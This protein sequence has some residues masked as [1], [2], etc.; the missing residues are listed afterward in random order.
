M[1]ESATFDYVIVGA[2]SAGCVLA[3]RLSEDPDVRVEDLTHAA[4]PCEAFAHVRADDDFALFLND[5]HVDGFVN[6]GSNGSDWLWWRGPSQRV[7]DAMRTPV[8]LK[9]GRN[10]VLLKVKN[11]RGGAGFVLAFSRRDG[12]P[13][14]GLTCDMA[15]ADPPAEAEKADWKTVVR[16]VFRTKSFKSKLD[17]AVGG[18]KVV[19]R[20]LVGTSNSKGVAWRKHTVRP[21][22]PKD[23]P[24]N[25][26]WLREKH[27]EDL[28]AMR[29][30]LE[31]ATG[32]QKAP[33]I[34]VT[35]QGEGN[36]DGLSGWNLIVHPRGKQVGARLERYDRVVYQT[37]P[38][39]RPKRK[40]KDDDG[41]VPLV[42]EYRDGRVTATL[43]TLVLFD[44]VPVRPI[45]GRHRVGFATFGAQPGLVSFRLEAA[46]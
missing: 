23:A 2:G 31:L 43:G 28:D 17:T 26:A 15:P 45:P 5:E 9:Q 3:N 42:L 16:H 14:G 32:N 8:M 38:L 25:L 13:I 10:K 27:T 46:K 39:D 35:F 33:K 11:R 37:R 40:K 36:T 4:D 34:V 44:R 22:F 30:T 6:R 1:T 7:P 41:I 18:F 19:N 21:G 29:L 24:S 12:G 20:Q